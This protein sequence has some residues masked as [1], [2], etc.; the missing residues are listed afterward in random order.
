[1]YSLEHGWVCSNLA[2]GSQGVLVPAHALSHSVCV[3]IQLLAWLQPFLCFFMTM[4]IDIVNEKL[5]L[6]A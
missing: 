1:M 3:S 2:E 4:T 5:S 6:S